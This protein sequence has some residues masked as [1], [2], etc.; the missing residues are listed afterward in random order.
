MGMENYNP[1]RT[2]MCV[3]EKLL[4]DES[5]EKADASMFRSLSGKLLYITHT[6]PDVS[7]AVNSLSR[8]LSNPCK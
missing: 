2:P 4:C 7:F 3:N 6:L 1:V 5:S 8:F